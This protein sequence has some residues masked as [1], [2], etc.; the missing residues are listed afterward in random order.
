MQKTI[1]WKV[2]RKT[3]ANFKSKLGLAL[4]TSCLAF[5]PALRADMVTDW[6][7]NLDY[8]IE[9]VAQPVPTQ[10]RF[11]AI[12]HT[13]IYDAVNG[14]EQKYDPYFVTEC[15]PQGAGPRPPLPWL[16]TPRCSVFIPL[17]K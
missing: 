11:I 16:P 7:A 5:G 14:I 2:A 6:S 4:I 15:A 12:V 10:A 8:I 1:E 9:S 17:R 3:F 13:A